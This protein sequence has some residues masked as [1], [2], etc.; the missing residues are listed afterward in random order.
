[1]D[2]FTSYGHII[3]ILES[4]NKISDF[5]TILAWLSRFELQLFDVAHPVS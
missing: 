1:M 5:L 4:Q 3:I 2:M